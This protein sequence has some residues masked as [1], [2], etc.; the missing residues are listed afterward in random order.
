MDLSFN[1]DNNKT[2]NYKNT[3]R[4]MY[5]QCVEFQ[6]RKSIENPTKYTIDANTHCRQYIAQ[7]LQFYADK[8]E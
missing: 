1:I 6:T 4:D 8:N 2:N 5:V 7:Q 3:L